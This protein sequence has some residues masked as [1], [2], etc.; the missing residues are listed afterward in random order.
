[1]LSSVLLYETVHSTLLSLTHLQDVFVR[2]TITE[3][4]K[5]PRA[6]HVTSTAAAD[7]WIAL[8]TKA[9]VT[10][11]EASAAF[12][13]LPPV[14]AAFLTRGAGEWQG[15]DLATGHPTQ[16]TMLA[17]HWAGKTFRSA[18]DVDPIVVYDGDADAKKRRWNQDWGHARVS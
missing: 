2:R 12:A 18:E 3:P 10:P 7:A 5:R 14:T 11:D 4:P 16:Q 9:S 15:A 8:T 1:M 17:L 13:A 6:N